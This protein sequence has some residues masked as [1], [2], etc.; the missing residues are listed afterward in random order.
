MNNTI[1]NRYFIYAF[2]SEEGIELKEVDKHAFD[3]EDGEVT[4]ER[5]TMFTNGCSQVCH[6]KENF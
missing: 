3:E 5:H 2:D 1:P 4:T 6:T